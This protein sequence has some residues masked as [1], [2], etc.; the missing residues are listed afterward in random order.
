MKLMAG[1]GVG[2]PLIVG[3][4]VSSTGQRRSAGIAELALSSPVPAD[5]LLG[6]SNLCFADERA[7]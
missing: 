3:Q 2:L 4:R 7:G 1:E 5:G 6:S